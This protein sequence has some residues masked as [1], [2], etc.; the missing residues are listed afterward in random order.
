MEGTAV[1]GTVGLYIEQRDS[2]PVRLRKG[3]FFLMST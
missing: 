1:V 2:F 3:C